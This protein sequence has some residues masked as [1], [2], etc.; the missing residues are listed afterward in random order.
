MLRPVARGPPFRPIA[1]RIS[2]ISDPCIARPHA[3]CA[4]RRSATDPTRRVSTVVT[5]C[6]RDSRVPD[7]R[8]ATRARPNRRAGTA[9]RIRS[10]SPDVPTATRTAIQYVLVCPCTYYCPVCPCTYYVVHTCACTLDD[11]STQGGHER[12][13]LTYSCTGTHSNA[14]GI[15]PSN[16]MRSPTGQQPT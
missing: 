10:G 5:S 2:A 12:S 16:G 15:A 8:T 13:C 6:P 7:R 14:N 9:A 11:T 3:A 4:R 1:I